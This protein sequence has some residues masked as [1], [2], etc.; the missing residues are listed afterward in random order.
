MLEMINH[1]IAVVPAIDSTVAATGAVIVEFVLR[2]LPSQ[3]P[4]SI[5]HVVAGALQSIGVGLKKV[6]DLLDKVLPQTIK[7]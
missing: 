3:K 6:G 2:L 1:W 4:L 5:A 7:G